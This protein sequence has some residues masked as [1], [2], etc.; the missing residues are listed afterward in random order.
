F[1][2]KKADKPRLKKCAL[3][4]ADEADAAALNQAIAH[5]QAISDGTDL[6]RDLGNLPGNVCTPTYLATAAKALAEQFKGT[7]VEVLEEKDM[8]ALGM[9]SLLSVSAGSAEPA[10]LIR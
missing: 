1:K 9:G 10:K 7:E 4:S 2:S 6:T 8:E 5:G 3:W